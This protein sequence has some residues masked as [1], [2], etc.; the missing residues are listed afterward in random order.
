MAEQLLIGEV[1]ALTGIASGR[2]RHYE[3]IGLL[4]AQ[5]LSNGYRVFD[6]EQVLDLLRIDL[7]RS[8]GVSIND[9]QRLV[10]GGQTTL[11]ELLDEHRA[12]LIHQRDRLDRL[13]AA[14]DESRES[15]A[16]GDCGTGGVN[17]HI[18]RTL[19]TT[20]RDS[21]GVIGRL[22]APLSVPIAAMY[23]DLFDEWQLPVPALFGQMVLPPA[24][25]TLLEQ[26]AETPGRRVLFDRLRSLAGEVIAL[27]E[28]L[29]AATDLAGT[30][31]AQQL[32][33]PL[34]ED[35]VSAL[36]GVQPLLERD[37]VIVQGFR[38]WARSI[39]PAAA[40]F[41]EEM[42]AQTAQRGLETVS[43][44]VLPRAKPATHQM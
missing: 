4:R 38:A 25:S 1:T 39:N 43:V 9:I 27:G 16:A 22:S 6:V 28:N 29:S 21:I 11:A 14:I 30:W 20:H 32:A 36:R 24:A 33:D 5:H 42:A 13:I 34:P 8:L 19:A 3:K 18:L 44:I 35:V 15:R 10:G 31:I 40:H 23:S 41:I 7:M 12:L 17:E 37:P 2:I 26:L